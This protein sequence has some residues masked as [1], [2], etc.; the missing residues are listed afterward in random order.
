MASF[1]CTPA[2]APRDCSTQHS[3]KWQDA[4]SKLEF[5]M[6]IASVVVAVGLAEVIAGW[7]RLLQSTN[8]KHQFKASR[9]L[10]YCKH[11]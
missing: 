3:D 9:R 11:N 4:M 10:R 8:A 7:G 2:A 1:V 5:L 6:M